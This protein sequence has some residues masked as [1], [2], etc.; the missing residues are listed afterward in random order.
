[1]RG[2]DNHY[3][4]NNNDFT[5]IQKQFPYIPGGGGFSSAISQYISESETWS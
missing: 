5:M 4:T 2:L 3:S 1:M